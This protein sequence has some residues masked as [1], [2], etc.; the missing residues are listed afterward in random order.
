MDLITVLKENNAARAGLS[1]KVFDYLNSDI[2]QV[3]MGYYRSVYPEVT[4]DTFL[5]KFIDG[6]QEWGFTRFWDDD[7]ESL[8]PDQVIAWCADLFGEGDSLNPTLIPFDGDPKEGKVYLALVT[9]EGLPMN[10]KHTRPW[11]DPAKGGGEGA[12][13][14]F[15]M[16]FEDKDIAM[17][18]L[19][20]KGKGFTFLGEC[21]INSASIGDV[22]DYMLID[23]QE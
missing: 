10:R 1:S 18:G 14:T 22:V 6:G 13:A 21:T 23:S 3:L 8:T 5:R 19:Y 16:E 4:A 20:Q 12:T 11:T 2:A 17:M 7:T 9:M 15:T